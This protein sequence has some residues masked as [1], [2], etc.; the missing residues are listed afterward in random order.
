MKVLQSDKRIGLENFSELKSRICYFLVIETK[1]A[2]IQARGKRTRL[3]PFRGA[4][5]ARRGTRESRFFHSTSSAGSHHALHV[6]AQE[7]RSLAGDALSYSYKQPKMWLI[8]SR[9]R[10]TRS[11]P[12]EIG[13]RDLVPSQ[14]GMRYTRDLLHKQ[15]VI[16]R[17]ISHHTTISFTHASAS[18][19]TS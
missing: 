9:V 13:D 10:R 8:S 12:D 16:R 4:R 1:D 15:R 5:S 19:E 14:L 6:S 18:W 2:Q 17:M 3:R 7:K 11:M